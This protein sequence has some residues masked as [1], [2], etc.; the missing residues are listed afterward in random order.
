MLYLLLIVYFG[1]AECVF[2][3]CKPLRGLC[4]GEEVRV[5][6]RKNGAG[7]VIRW[8]IGSSTRGKNPCRVWFGFYDRLGDSKSLDGG[9]DG[10][11]ATLVGKMPNS[12][13]LVFNA[14]EDLSNVT[15]GD[16]SLLGGHKLCPIVIKSKS[17]INKFGGGGITKQMKNLRNWRRHAHQNW[18][19]CMLHQPLLA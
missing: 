19:T 9:C 17:L 10:S 2:F 6:C 3:D 1:I 18:C 15:C 7:N 12:S 8:S 14:T 4:P 11:T 16:P 5:H 13:D